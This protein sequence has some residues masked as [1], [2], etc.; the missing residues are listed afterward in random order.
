MKIVLALSAVLLSGAALADIPPPVPEN[1]LD[2]DCAPF[3]GVWAPTTPELSRGGSRTMVLAVGSEKASVIV[4]NNQSGVFMEPMAETGG[5]ACEA[6]ADGVTVLTFTGPNEVTIELTAKL[7]GETTFTTSREAAYL[8]PG[9]PPEG[10][11][12]ETVTTTWV[13]IAK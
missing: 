4:Y 3:V 13:R 5:L 6:T 10:W 7:A 9:P 1:P 11:K 8:E 2:A 12:P